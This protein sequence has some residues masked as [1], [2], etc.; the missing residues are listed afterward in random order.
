MPG[1]CNS[2]QIRLIHINYS[3]YN[4]DRMERFSLPSVCEDNSWKYHLKLQQQHYHIVL[5][6]TWCSAL[7]HCETVVKVSDSLPWSVPVKTWPDH[8]IVSFEKTL[9]NLHGCF[10]AIFWLKSVF[11]ISA[12][13]NNSMSSLYTSISIKLTY[14][15]VLYTIC[16]SWGVESNFVQ[17]FKKK[18]AFR[19]DK[20]GKIWKHPYLRK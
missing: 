17:Y 1:L 5:W 18:Y 8:E 14:L 13:V 20:M 3:E 12:A 10:L 9:H 6:I 16:L 2:Y 11:F 15:H 4:V 19:C 7:G